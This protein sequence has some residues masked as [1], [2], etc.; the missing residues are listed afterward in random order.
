MN[1]AWSQYK[2]S[3]Y[4]NQVYILV[5]EIIRKW[6]IL[7]TTCNGIK[8]YEVIRDK[9][10]VIRKDLYT[11]IYNTLPRVIVEDLKK[12]WS[13]PCLH[14]RRLNIVKEAI[15]P[16]LICIFSIIPTK[17]LPSFL[18]KNRQADSKMCK[19]MHRI[20]SS[21]NNHEKEQYQRTDN[22]WTWAF[23]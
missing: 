15:L 8:K 9:L 22:I 13:I 20:C 18:C 2:R 14:I 23:L 6:K 16:R 3:I 1:L 19:E 21:Q 7:N 5:L 10:Y 17:I 12:L 4:K 11:E